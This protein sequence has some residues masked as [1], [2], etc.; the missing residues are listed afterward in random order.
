M[1]SIKV[2][3]KLKGFCQRLIFYQNRSMSYGSDQSYKRGNPQ[4]F[5]IFDVM[6]VVAASRLN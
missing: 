6:I 2:D 5:L 4:S 3:E 1:Y